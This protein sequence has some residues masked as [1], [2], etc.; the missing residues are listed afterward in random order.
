LSA[1]ATAAIT[2]ITKILIAMEKNHHTPSHDNK[3]AAD[4]KTKQKSEGATKFY[5]YSYFIKLYP[6]LLLLLIVPH[7]VF[8][9]DMIRLNTRHNGRISNCCKLAE[10][11]EA[12]GRMKDVLC[13]NSLST[14]VV[15][16]VNLKL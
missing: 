7:V 13:C 15:T 5:E 6:L 14:I 10:G 8:G 1:A 12:V 2:T 9:W 4:V 3:Y 16:T 11:Q